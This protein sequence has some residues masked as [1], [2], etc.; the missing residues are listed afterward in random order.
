MNHEDMITSR[1]SGDIR[2][3]FEHDTAEHVMT[4]L[5]D[6]GLYRHLRFRNP[7]SAIYYFDLVT[8]PGYL[9]I[10]G[11]AG[12]FLFART[13]DMFTFFEGSEINPHY[14]SEK[15]VAPAGR[16]SVREFSRSAYQDL[17]RAWAAEQSDEVATAALEEL[18]SEDIHDEHHARQMLS[19]FSR[20]DARIVDSW[21]WDMCQFSFRFLWCCWA[22]HNGI[23]RYRAHQATL[24]PSPA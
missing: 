6:D 7:A 9:A 20:G 12:D 4:V 14:W 3:V 10:S 17:V 1:S 11:D 18:I 5:H 21:E 19:D 8:W 24:T 22:I 2:R 15:L 16:R 23:A 13:E